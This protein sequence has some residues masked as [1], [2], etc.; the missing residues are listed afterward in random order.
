LTAYTNFI[1]FISVYQRCICLIN[2]THDGRSVVVI[3]SC[4]RHSS[5]Y[6][7]NTIHVISLWIIV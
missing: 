6:G 3:M 1:S 4:D 5:K 7:Q 2:Y